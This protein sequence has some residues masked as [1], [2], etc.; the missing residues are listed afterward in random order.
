M[1]MYGILF[2][3]VLFGGIIA[4][5]VF[6]YMG[7]TL[8][9]V[10]IFLCLI[11]LYVGMFVARPSKHFESKFLNVIA[12]NT[13]SV[14][15]TVGVAIMVLILGSPVMK[16]LVI[17]GIAVVACWLILLPNFL[18]REFG[19]LINSKLDTGFNPPWTDIVYGFLGVVMFIGALVM[20]HYLV[21]NA[22][23]E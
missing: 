15:A 13:T 19:M 20:Q 23:T 3:V 9:F 5:S 17:S 4:L 2:V 10:I 1:D 21:D 18:R 6:F 7:S 8:L 16:R 22:S 14:I 11:V 12:S